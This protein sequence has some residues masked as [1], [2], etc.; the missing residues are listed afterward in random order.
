MSKSSLIRFTCIRVAPPRLQRDQS[1]GSNSNEGK[2]D[3]NFT[4]F[5]YNF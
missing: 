5:S 1:K 3:Q 4:L 2:M